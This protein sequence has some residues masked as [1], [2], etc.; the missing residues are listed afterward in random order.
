MTLSWPQHD[1]KSNAGGLSRLDGKP[2]PA[3]GGNQQSPDLGVS[4]RFTLLPRCLTTGS[5]QAMDRLGQACV[6]ACP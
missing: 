4:V 5:L 6:D 3:Q 1:P 2:G